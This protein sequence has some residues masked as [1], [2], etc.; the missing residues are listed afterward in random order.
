MWACKR[1]VTLDM[2]SVQGHGGPAWKDKEPS[3][4]WSGRDSRQERLDLVALS[5]RYPDLLNASLTNFF[6]FRDK[7]EEYGPQ[8]SHIS[9]FE[10]FKVSC[11]ACYIAHSQVGMPQTFF[12]PQVR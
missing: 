2:L 9:F 1:R 4:F 7:M 10:F 3:G 5:R 6:F 11:M 8:A 12:E